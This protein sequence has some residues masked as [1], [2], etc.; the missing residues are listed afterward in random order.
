MTGIAAY[1]PGQAA[2]AVLA[3]VRTAF[4]GKPESFE[5]L[6]ENVWNDAYA[7][8]SRQGVLS[9]AYDGIILLP[10]ELRPSGKLLLRW[11]VNAAASE[12]RYA[13][14]TAALGKLAALYAGNSI[15]ILL[16]KGYGLSLYYPVPQHRECGDIDVYLSGGFECA[17]RMAR[18]AGIGVKAAVGKHSSFV[19]EGVMVENHR[20]IVDEDR[21][22][23]TASIERLLEEM[24]AKDDLRQI[25][26]DG[27][28]VWLPT[29]DFNA[30]YLLA[31]A[32]S[33]FRD[34]ELA[35]RNLCDWARFLAAEG[36][37]I[38]RESLDIILQESRLG[39]LYGLMNGFCERWLGLPPQEWPETDG[40]IRRRFDEMIFG[41]RTIAAPE[42]EKPAARIR[43]IW[44][45]RWRYRD[46]LHTGFVREL[47]HTAWLRRQKRNAD[48][49]K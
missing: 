27:E 14:Q 41:Y 35:L 29:P 40:E 32:S 10:E 42:N 17:N 9:V 30:V 22:R 7:F 1:D 4:G 34:G 24:A 20:V 2:R 44:G 3:L 46:V 33:H 49:S 39:T 8:A 36:A 13:R 31:H 26:V 21:N 16:L 23:R 19:F 12:D 43:R 15:T 38:D 5:K 25:E 45:T 18:E 6:S 28:S 37:N 48:K 11:G 47:V